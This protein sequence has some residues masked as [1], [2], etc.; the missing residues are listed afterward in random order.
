[1][2]ASSR[3]IYFHHIPKTAGSSVKI[4]LLS[5]LG[6]N[7]C[8]AEVADHLV[9]M[10][11]AKLECYRGFTGHFHGYLAQYL[12]RELLTF[13][14]LRNPVARSR[15]HWHQVRRHAHHPHHSRVVAQSFTE[16]VSDDR[17]RVLLENYQAR[18]LAD[19]P[20]DLRMLAGRFSNDELSQYALAEALEQASLKVATPVLAANARDALRRMAVVEV[21]ERGFTISSSGW[22]D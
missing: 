9:R 3:T 18:Y 12:G 20:I 5:W 8:P 21:S 14:V 7:L 16:F 10:P 19:L 4:W 17:N 2:T 11:F 15:S 1:M 22:Q 13:T 6:I